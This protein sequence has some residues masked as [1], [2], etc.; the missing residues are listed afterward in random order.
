MTIGNERI[1]L[2]LPENVSSE[3]KPLFEK[4]DSAMKDGNLPGPT[5]FGN[6]VRALAHNPKLLQALTQVYEVFAETQ[7]VDRKLVELGILVVSRINACEYCIQHHAP[8]AHDAGLQKEQLQSIQKE[9]WSERQALWSEVEWLI[10][11]YAEQMTREPY[12]ITDNL[13]EQL[14]QYFTDT[15][16]VDLTM[17]FALCSAWNKFNDALQLDT[18]SAVQHTF[19]ELGL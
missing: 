1:E 17:R 12:K 14:H 9:D 18:E 3:L 4:A 15:E 16:I 8:L 10:I 19:V 5:L 6:Q 13:F 11:Q 2:V 7:T